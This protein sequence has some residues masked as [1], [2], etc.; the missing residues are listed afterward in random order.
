[1]NRSADPT[2]AQEIKG[3]LLEPL[4]RSWK[5]YAKNPTGNKNMTAR[6]FEEVISFVFYQELSS[7]SVTVSKRTKYLIWEDISINADCLIQKEGY[8]TCILSMKTWIGDEQIRETFASAYFAKRWHAQENIRVYMIIFRPIPRR[9]L[10]LIK[11]CSPHID[12]VYSLCGQ[13][14][15]DTLVEDLQKTYDQ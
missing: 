9:L 3:I 15:I 6:P 11:V 7:L 10:E 1:M 8:P 13:P 5:E 14:Y 12:G 2:L 4:I